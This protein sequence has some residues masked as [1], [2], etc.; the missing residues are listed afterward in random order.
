MSKRNLLPRFFFDVTQSD[1][2]PDCPVRF[3]THNGQCDGH[4]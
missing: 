1:G 3:G 2:D 4:W